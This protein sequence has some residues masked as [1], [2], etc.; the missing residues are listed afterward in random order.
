MI[1]PEVLRLAPGS[2]VGCTKMD[3]GRRPDF[4][5]LEEP[6]SRCEAKGRHQ[7]A[8]WKLRKHQEFTRVR[9][10]QGLHEEAK[11][12]R[13]QLGIKRNPRRVSACDQALG[14]SGELVSINAAVVTVSGCS[15]DWRGAQA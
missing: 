13:K 15:D 8:G 4:L 6:L 3:L 14:S 10:R 2:V 12:D 1:V 5:F 7:P 11:A 9:A